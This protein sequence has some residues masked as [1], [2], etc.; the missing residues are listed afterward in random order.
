VDG[1]VFGDVRIDAHAADGVPDRFRR[2][3]GVPIM[4]AVMVA[5]VLASARL[6]PFPVRFRGPWLMGAHVSSPNP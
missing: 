6:L 3:R 5:V 2:S 4:L 1:G